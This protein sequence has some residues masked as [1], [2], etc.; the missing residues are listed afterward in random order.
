M[1]ERRQKIRGTTT[2]L[3]QEVGL[4]GLL[5]YDTQLHELR[6]FDGVSMGGYRI[7]NLTTI[8]SLYALPDRLTTDGKSLAGV[9][10]DTATEAGFYSTDATTTGLPVAD[11]GVLLAQVSAAMTSQTWTRDDNTERWRRTKI[12]AGAWSSWLREIDLTYLTSNAA[13]VAYDA[14][15]LDGQDSTYYTD[16]AARLGYTPANK[17]GE[18]FT[19]AVTFATTVGITGTL[20]GAAAN[21]SGAVSAAS[22]TLTT[23]LAI[24][25]GGS[26]ASTAA[27]ARTNFDVYSK[28]EVDSMVSAALPVAAVIYTADN[29][30]PTGYLKANGAAVSRTTYSALFAAIGTTYGSG[31]GST[32]F[33]VPDLRGEFIRGLDDGRGVDTGRTL[34]SFQADQLESHTHAVDPPSTTTS[35][36]AHTHTV[37]GTTSSN[38]A[39]SHEPSAGTGF[40]ASGGGGGFFGSGTSSDPFNSA[41]STNSTG[42]HTHTW[43]GT[44]S[45]DSHSHT[46][47]IASFTSG[48]AGAGTE[49]RPRNVALLACIKF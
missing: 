16:I 21:F 22:L 19:G 47:N 5:A 3:D 35:S 6:V 20:T 40:V 42:A 30:A 41:A 8:D 45:S 27:A 46:V 26:G 4:I 13:A 32:T 10:A 44:T 12:G 23:D 28:A 14:N 17:A 9:S 29:V 49:T 33:N 24:A 11:V 2:Q 37:S 31:D 15:R 39:H 43:S 36:D 38:G 7:P 18:A 34:G 48:A 25:Q 1:A